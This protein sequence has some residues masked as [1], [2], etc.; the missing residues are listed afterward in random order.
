MSEF[1]DAVR[2]M[3]GAPDDA[4]VTSEVRGGGS[5]QIGDLTWDTE[6]EEITVEARI[7]GVGRAHWERKFNSLPE[8]W[9]ALTEEQP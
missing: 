8:L 7:P 9:A 2:R 5:V 6:D 1:D 4:F 3:L